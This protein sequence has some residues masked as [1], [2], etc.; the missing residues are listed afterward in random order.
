MTDGYERGLL[1]NTALLASTFGRSCRVDEACAKATTAV[2][3]S[4]HVRS[5]RGGAY[6]ADRQVKAL[7]GLMDAAGV[8][9]PV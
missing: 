7:Y 1:F 3:M 6:L 9:T 2:R 5:V 4:N 8:P